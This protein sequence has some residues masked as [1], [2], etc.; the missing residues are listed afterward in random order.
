MLEHKALSFCLVNR[1]EYAKASDTR[2]S[3]GDAPRVVL[4]PLLNADP[5]V[6]TVPKPLQAEILAA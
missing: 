4:S 6:D 5:R 3:N 2:D 1:V